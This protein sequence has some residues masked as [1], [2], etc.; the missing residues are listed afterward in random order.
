M[1]YKLHKNGSFNIHTIK[2]DR[3]KNIQMEILFRNNI[4]EKNVHK[5]VVLFDTLMA[6]SEAYK[7][8]REI[9]LKLEDLYNASCY[10]RTTKVGGEVIS[11][12]TM[13][14]LNPKYAGE[15]YLSEAIKLPFDLLFYPNVKNNEFANA[16]LENVKNQVIS[17]IKNT[18]ENPRKLSIQKAIE[19]AVPKSIS[20]VSLTGKESDIESITAANLYEEYQNILKHDYVDIFIIGDIEVDK[21][22][23][24]IVKNAPFNT[25][26]THEI[27]MNI[28][29]TPRKKV[30]EVEEKSDFSQ[31]QLVYVLNTLNLTE[32]EK[33]YPFLIYNLI[34]G[35]GSLETKLYR[36]LRDEH[37]LCYNVLS[38]FQKYDNLE[39]IQT[40]IDYKNVSLA[41]KLINKTLQ[42][43]E[44]SVTEEEVSRAVLAII[45]SIHVS[46]DDPAK[47]IDKY[48][49]E[50][51]GSIDS[52]DERIEKFKK[53]T[54]EDV[55]RIAK[56]VKVNTIY[57]LR[58]GEKHED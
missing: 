4:D 12:I 2:T 45:S 20:S 40:G 15:D 44:N 25:I 10:A 36:H 55:M 7:T 3:F 46:L 16:P 50:Y 54:K 39:I 37:S 11:S 28:V 5:R 41:K 14:F 1:V 18:L 48:F 19:K 30:Q 53:V 56:K 57:V 6:S 42:E 58:G 31:S 38:L 51:L 17:D 43:M 35:G 49:F 8:K 22:I 33:R 32:E 47:I 23:S 9:A 29:H 52:M 34:L 24:E 21:V 27:E 13:D 26:K